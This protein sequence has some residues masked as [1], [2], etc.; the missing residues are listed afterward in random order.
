MTCVRFSTARRPSLTLQGGN[1]SRRESRQT[2]SGVR[3]RR[4]CP[5]PVAAK[6][7]D[8]VGRPDQFKNK[9]VSVRAETVVG[10]EM[11]APMDGSCPNQRVWFELDAPKHDAEY[12]NINRAWKVNPFN[13]RKKVTATL[14]G[15]YDTDQWFGHQCFSH[16]QLR[17][18]Q[19][20]NVMAVARR[21]APD[22]S[23]YDC[24]LLTR[25]TQVSFQKGHIDNVPDE[26]AF[27]RSLE[28]VLTGPDGRP[29]I[30]EA[31]PILQIAL[32]RT[33]LKV[34][35]SRSGVFQLPSLSPGAYVFSAVALGFQSVSG[36]FVITPNA[37]GRGPLRIE[38]PLG[39]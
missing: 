17:I 15:Y 6:L 31:K 34:L 38:L 1:L 9:L 23:A 20:L 14:I 24:S 7:C 30:S 19:F 25:D 26:P 32:T 33:R 4:T 29:I 12:R 37:T 3:M 8:M 5:V 18:R 16:T 39:V 11:Q 36:C 13:I 21:L 35:E 2:S 27:I 22:F 28:V 10:F